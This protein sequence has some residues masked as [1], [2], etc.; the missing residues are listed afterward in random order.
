MDYG[1]NKVFTGGGGASTDGVL[2]DFPFLTQ[3]TS[4]RTG[5]AG[6]RVQNGWNAITRPTS[7]KA[8]AELDTSLGAN[9][10]FRL[11]NDLVV[12]G[13]SSKI[14]YV[15][16][17]GGQTWSATNNVNAVILDKLTGLMTT[18]NDLGGGSV[19]W[20][21][22]IDNALTYS[23][24]V[25][26]VLYDDWYLFSLEEVYKIFGYI[27][28]HNQTDPI[29]AAQISNFLNTGYHT[30][31]TTPDSTLFSNSVA[32]DTNGISARQTSKGTNTRQIYVRK[33]QNLITAP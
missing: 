18:R 20:N 14:R 16:V 21:T 7:P 26:G 11:K 3:Y 30:A 28:V 8:I 33:A 2:L 5:D 13:V 27:W 9:M 24:T 15:D 17:L 12:N 29:S 23:I 1:F 22:C 32:I 6:W 4:F 25:N 31:N 19:I 10:Y